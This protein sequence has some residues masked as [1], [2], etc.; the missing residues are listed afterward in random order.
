ME[1]QGPRELVSQERPVLEAQQ[2]L[3]ELRAQWV[4]LVLVVLLVRMVWMALL[5]FLQQVQSSPLVVRQPQAAGLPVTDRLCLRRPTQR[6]LPSSVSPL[7]TLEAVISACLTFADVSRSDRTHL[8]HSLMCLVTMKARHLPTVVQA[9]ITPSALVQELGAWAE[10]SLLRL[11]RIHPAEI[12]WTNRRI[13][14]STS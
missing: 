5:A 14:P 9:T 13:R 1:R 10:H 11:P 2:V 6:S 4:Q 12:S 3:L 7:E 8:T